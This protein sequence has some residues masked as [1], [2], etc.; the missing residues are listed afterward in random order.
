MK[1]KTFYA[2]AFMGALAFSSCNKNGG[3]TAT[4]LTSENDKVS[5]SLGVMMGN[6]LKK[7]GVDTING[8]AL[9][10]AI[11][12]VY[13]SADLKVTEDSAKQILDAYFGKIRDLKNGKAI[14]EGKKFLEENKTKSGVVELPSGLQYQIITAGTGQKPTA[15]DKVTVNYTGKLLNG[16]V[17]DSSVERKQPASFPVSGVIPG[18]TEALQLMPVGS[19]WNLYIPSN[20]AYGERGA[21]GTIPPNSTLVFEVELL[22]IDK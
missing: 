12:D 2:A 7:S 4:S 22:S 6:N 21:G 16:T 14:E 17:F 5:Y 13:A 19:K 1:I 9:A 10:A 18:W 11:S 8:V 20:L 3:Q 15:T